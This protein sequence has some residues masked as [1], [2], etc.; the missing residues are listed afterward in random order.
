[1]QSTDAVHYDSEKDIV[2]SCDASP[3]GIGAAL[4]YQMPNRTERPIGFAS[5]M[6]N[7]A[8]KNYS[9]LDK[10]GLAVTFGI[11]RFH[12]YLYG[13]KF[14]I[15]TDHKPLLL[16][17]SEMQAIPLMVST[18]IQIWAVILRAY[19]FRIVY[20]EGKNHSNADALSCLPLPEQ[21]EV[22]QSEERVLMLHRHHAGV[23]RTSEEM[24][25]RR[26]NSLTGARDG[27]QR[28]VLREA[29]IGNSS[30]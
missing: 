26:S 20:K 7:T 1:M 13:R 28:V 3:Y 18:R 19:G 29:W 24:D 10:E 8:E 11:K 9:Q 22:S 27:S 2:L 25:R 5:H 15:V 14:T 30:I 12:Q 6:L 23:G 4:S 16:L 17:F 21:P